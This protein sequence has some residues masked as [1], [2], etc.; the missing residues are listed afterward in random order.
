MSFDMVDLERVLAIAA[1]PVR[2][3]LVLDDFHAAAW[4]VALFAALPLNRR[5][6]VQ[7]PQRTATTT[8]ESFYESTKEEF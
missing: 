7:L 4:R 8:R 3:R 1:R 2:V 5:D 6:M